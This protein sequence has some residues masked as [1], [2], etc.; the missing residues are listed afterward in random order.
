VIGLL[1]LKQRNLEGV[2]GMEVE[3]VGLEVEIT[4]DGFTSLRYEDGAGVSHM[5]FDNLSLERVIQIFTQANRIENIAPLT[6][7]TGRR[8][9][10]LDVALDHFLKEEFGFNKVGEIVQP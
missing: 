1:T 2:N 6:K 9:V 4:S 3:L 7:G 5:N 10:K 8:I